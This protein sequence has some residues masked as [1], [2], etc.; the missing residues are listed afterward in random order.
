MNEEQLIKAYLQKS[1]KPVPSPDFNEKIVGKLSELKRSSGE[2]APAVFDE[3]PLI[4]VTL[5][6]ALVILFLM[7]NEDFRYGILTSFLLFLFIG[8]ALLANKITKKTISMR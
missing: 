6:A 3:L 1:I 4:I 7:A 5:L 2:K 8:F